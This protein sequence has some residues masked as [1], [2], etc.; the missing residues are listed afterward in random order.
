[1]DRAP[2]I[3]AFE[4]LPKYCHPKASKIDSKWDLH[5]LLFDFLISR[6]IVLIFFKWAIP[7]LFFFIFVFSTN[8]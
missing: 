2:M 7:S 5:S 3:V 8:I 4:A 6:Q 1:M